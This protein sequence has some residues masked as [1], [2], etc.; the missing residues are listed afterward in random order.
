MFAEALLTA[1]AYALGWGFVRLVGPGPGPVLRLIAAYPLGVSLWVLCAIAMLVAGL[2]F[3]PLAVTLVGF[4]TL[5]GLNWRYGRPLNNRELVPVAAGGILVVASAAGLAVLDFSFLTSDSLMILGVADQIATYR[6]LVPSLR[7]SLASFP[8]YLSL[9]YA[10]GIELG[11]PYLRSL[12]PLFGLACV[13]TTILFLRHVV[14]REGQ[15]LLVR[16]LPFL[17]GLTLA[18]MPLFVWTAGYVNG[19]IVF[20]WLMLVACGGL[21]LAAV[22]HSPGW[23]L[24][25]VTATACIAPLR[26]EAGLALLPLLVAAAAVRTVPLSQRLATLGGIGLAVG[27]WYAFLLIKSFAHGLLSVYDLFVIGAAPGLFGVFT[28]CLAALLGRI[29]PAATERILAGLPWAMIVVLVLAIAAQSMLQPAA[30]PRALYV[31]GSFL[32]DPHFGAAGY[33]LTVSILLLLAPFTAPRHPAC[34]LVALPAAAYLL[35]VFMIGLRTPWQNADI[36]DS[37]NRMLIHILPSLVFYV[38]ARYAGHR[39]QTNEELAARP[40]S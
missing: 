18:T 17:A 24:L 37:T 23:W 16:L 21:Y 25:A 36:S 7:A 11:L 20:A 28:L 13:A 38:L 14:S 27:G 26:M 1:A 5:G 2:P 35:V 29:G 19:H 4:C 15:S 39:K 32:V 3:H 10:S 22:E 34:R 12:T 33:T 9:A 30:L 6:G 40:A 8:L 31:F